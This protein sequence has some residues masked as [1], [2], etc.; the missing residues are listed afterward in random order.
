MIYYYY[1]KLKIG[2]QKPFVPFSLYLF[3]FFFFL[4]NIFSGDFQTIN[5]VR[6]STKPKK[7]KR[8]KKGRKR[9]KSRKTLNL[10]NLYQNILSP[11]WKDKTYI[12]LSKK[13]KVQRRSLLCKYILLFILNICKYILLP[14]ILNF[15]I[16]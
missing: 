16:N 8:K 7:E 5:V 11:N 6:N 14:C 15:I 12:I 2:T 4:I 9:N 13:F 10:A 1:F 3:K